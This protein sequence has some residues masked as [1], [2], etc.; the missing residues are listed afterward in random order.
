MYGVEV[1]LLPTGALKAIRRFKAYERQYGVTQEVL[2][3][4]YQA[5]EAAAKEQRDAGRQPYLITATEL[6]FSRDGY[7][8]RTTPLGYKREIVTELVSAGLKLYI[9]LQCKCYQHCL[10]CGVWMLLKLLVPVMLACRMLN[11]WLAAAFVR[12]AHCMQSRLY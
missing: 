6:K 5:S 11:A 9:H 4:A 12:L 1:T 7:E 10:L 8:V 2:K 3:A